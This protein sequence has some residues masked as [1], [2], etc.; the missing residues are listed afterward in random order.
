METNILSTVAAK[1]AAKLA[2]LTAQADAAAAKAQA[3]ND[4]A[5]SACRRIEG[6]LAKAHK[7][8]NEIES[9]RIIVG[10]DGQR[11]T[12]ARQACQYFVGMIDGDGFATQNWARIT[13]EM[14]RAAI[15]APVVPSEIA[16]REA[17]I[18]SAQSEIQQLT[19]A[20]GIEVEALKAA[21]REQMTERGQAVPSY[22]K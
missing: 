17:E 12:N 8:R 5:L 22:L 4:A 2:A 1:S 10:T 20:H 18:E 6:L 11:E 19:S 9:L 21:L 16:L 14:N 13:E 7:L 15:V 3:E